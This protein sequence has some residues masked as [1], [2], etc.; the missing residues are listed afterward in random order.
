MSLE[1]FSKLSPERPQLTLGFIPLTD[2]APLVAAQEYGFFAKHGLS[3]RLSREPS[4]ASLRDKIAFGLLDGAHMLAA[5]P[6]AATLG[7]N[8]VQ[9][10][11]L[12]AMSLDLNGNAIT[13]SGELYGQMLQAD[14]GGL[15]KRPVLAGPLKRVIESRRHNG[16]PP[17]TFATVFPFSSH[18]YELRWWMGQA[19]I[20][21]DRDV[22]LIIVPPPQMVERMRLGQI[23]GYCVGEPW[24]AMAVHTGLGRC[25]ITK[26]ELW[27]NS[28]EKVL[29]VTRD[30]AEANPNTHLALLG[31]L[32]E[33]CRWLDEPENRQ[34][35][36]GL[37]A[38]PRYVNAPAE[39]IGMS[40]TGTFQYLPGEPPQRM[41]DF[42]VF[43]RYAATYP[44]RSHARWFLERMQQAGQLAHLSELPDFAEV[45]RRVY[46]PELYRQAAQRLGVAAPLIDAK[47]EGDR[48]E[49]WVL[50]EA[51]EP[52][53]MGP[54]L[55]FDGQ[56]R[57]P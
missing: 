5:M 28:P 14:P 6:L 51:T 24:N 57:S 31:A 49:A 56:V 2:C 40:M 43:Y 36:I 9:K 50:H 4:W 37:L 34:R 30:W 55:M 21:P 1:P 33:A 19:G 52:I 27:N 38:E 26:H 11:M 42:N 13:V 53:T 12:T 41:P 39:V 22:R 18:H 20:D 3:V 47:P 7:V 46:R 44:W 32:L 17:L 29:G 16:L 15:T 54:S 8:G 23:D 35:I 48:A 10:P 45:A 25:L